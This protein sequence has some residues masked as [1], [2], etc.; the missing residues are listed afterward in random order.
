MGNTLLVCSE[1]GGDNIQFKIWVDANN[2]EFIRDASDGVINHCDDCN[3]EV[4]FE[5]EAEYNQNHPEQLG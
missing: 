5:S 3:K 4:D 2:G 1:C